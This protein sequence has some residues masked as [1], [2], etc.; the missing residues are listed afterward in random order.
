MR[1]T[2]ADLDRYDAEFGLSGTVRA[3]LFPSVR[4]AALAL[5]AA[6]PP[7]LVIAVGTV[8]LLREQPIAAVVAAMAATILFAAPWRTIMARRFVRRHME[9]V[10]VPQ[11]TPDRRRARAITGDDWMLVDE[12]RAARVAFVATEGDTVK[13]TLSSGQVRVLSANERVVVGS[14]VPQVMTPQERAR[15]A[16]PAAAA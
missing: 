6:V 14:L 13:V 10:S 1:M 4:L 8:T 7:I 15:L 16:R 5:L 9:K 3:E 2:L 12:D 11:F